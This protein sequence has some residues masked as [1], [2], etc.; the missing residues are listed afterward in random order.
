MALWSNHGVFEALMLIGGINF[1]E[2]FSRVRIFHGASNLEFECISQSMKISVSLFQLVTSVAPFDGADSH[3]DA[4]V[5]GSEPKH[6]K[7]ISRSR[8]DT[9]R[10]SKKAGMREVAS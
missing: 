9:P 10:A 1:D 6:A 3:C 5:L 2:S 8:R 4:V 7:S